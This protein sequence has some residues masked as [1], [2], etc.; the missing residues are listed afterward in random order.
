[1]ISKNFIW[2]CVV[3]VSLIAIIIND[4]LVV[5]CF[6]I[7]TIIISAMQYLKYRELE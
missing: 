7:P 2:W 5:F 3:I 1:M 4:D 6:L